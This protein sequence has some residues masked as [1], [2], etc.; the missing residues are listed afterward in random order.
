MNAPI[1]E[2]TT[3][4]VIEKKSGHQAMQPVVRPSWWG[5][6]RDM[7][8]RPGVPAQREPRPWPNSR[9]PPERQQGEPASLMHGGPNKEFPP[10]FGTAIP[11]KGLSG[12]VRR[13]AYQFPD[14]YPRYWLLKLL[15]DRIDSWEHRLARVLPWAVPL[16]GLAWLLTP[17]KDGLGPLHGGV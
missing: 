17:R 4:D 9:F 14:H 2:V 11:L 16:A 12:M 7:S 6:D 8:R 15:G 1:P 3:A 10:V 13:Y 5:V